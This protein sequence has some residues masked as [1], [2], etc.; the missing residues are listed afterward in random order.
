MRALMVA[1]VDMKQVPTRTAAKLLDGPRI[2]RFNR[3]VA[4]VGNVSSYQS[5]GHGACDGGY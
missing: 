4:E 5:G 2:K 1:P 3:A